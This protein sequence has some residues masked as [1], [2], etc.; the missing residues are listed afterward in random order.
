MIV[1]ELPNVITVRPAE[2]ARLLGV[3]RGTIYALAQRGEFRILKDGARSHIK[4][5]ELRA[6]VD[7]LP[8]I[9]GPPDNYDTER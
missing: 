4:I 2:A 7:R 8:S 1:Y 9:Y 6:Y 5:E 3:N